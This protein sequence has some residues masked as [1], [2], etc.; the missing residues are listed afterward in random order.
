[1]QSM[2]PVLC[3]LI[4]IRAQHLLKHAKDELRINVD[5]TPSSTPLGGARKPVYFGFQPA[6]QAK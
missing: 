6:L 4:F 3:N 5:V 1:M 2:T